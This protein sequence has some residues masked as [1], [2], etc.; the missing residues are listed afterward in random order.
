[1]SVTYLYRP[2]PAAVGRWKTTSTQALSS[3][4]KWVEKKKKNQSNSQRN[5]EWVVLVVDDV[6]ERMRNL[7]VWYPHDLAVDEV[8]CCLCVLLALPSCVV[9]SARWQTFFVPFDCC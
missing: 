4:N 2:T 8:I 1:M 6:P 9:L 7:A 3:K 5:R